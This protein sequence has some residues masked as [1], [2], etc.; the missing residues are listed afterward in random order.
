MLLSFASLHRAWGEKLTMKPS[1]FVAMLLT[2]SLVLAACSNNVAPPSTYTIS[3]TVV[4]LTGTNGGLVLQ[5]NLNDTLP[6]NAN[7]SFIFAKTVASGSSYNVAVSVQP[8]NPAQT[9]GVTS[10]SGI[11]TADITN[12]QVNCG[13]N[14]WAW[15]KGPNS[16]S[17]NGTYGTLGVPDPNN[18]PGGRQT[19]V[20]WTDA[21]GK[22][23]LF[24]GYG[25][26]SSGT[27]LPMNDVWEYSAGQWAWM[28]GSNLGGQNGTYGALGV[29][30]M[31]N[32]PGARYEAASWT[33]SSGA[34][35]L[36]G[37][38]GFDSAGTEAALNDMWKY[39]DG[40]WTWMGGS[41][42]AKQLGIYGTLGAPATNNTP[43]ARFGTVTWVD[44]S[45]NF[46]LFGGFGY[47]SN[48]SNGML[49][50]L[51]K[52]SNGQWTWESGSDVANQNGT[53]GIQGMPTPNNTPGARYWA[54]VWTD[55]S[56]NLWL[57][58]GTGYGASGSSGFLNDLWKYSNGQWTWVSGPSAISQP[59]VYGPEGVAASGNIPGSRQLAVSW[60]DSSGN[61]WLFGGNGI[62]SASATGL[63]N[64]L[65]KYSDGQWTWMSG[66]KVIN[67]QGVY[68]SPG[69]LAPGN[70]PGARFE[71]GHWVD[72]EGNLWLFGGYG[73]A[74]GTEGDLGDLWMYMP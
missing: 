61:F 7:G 69:V 66:S 59:G 16:V 24:G 10:G 19:P 43:G 67:Q 52:Y 68:G 18:N 32:I 21:S 4:N 6:V 39:S 33:D 62:D 2:S 70:I 46:W 12:V 30:A 11:A 42:V 49:N 51:W 22:L 50:D 40:E 17:V 15:M 45:G 37:G 31:S 9:C 8:S 53:Y 23:W 72:A 57:F 63:L 71:I 74:G 35:W 5:D 26:D 58:G 29:P 41:D 36:F 64:D 54:A 28:G 44:S 1:L 3:G 73:A 47:D 48:G 60:T 56:G 65:W 14:E 13:H 25:L 27:V 38:N 20:T 34:L 55:S